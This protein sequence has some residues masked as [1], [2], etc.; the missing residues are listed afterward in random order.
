MK[1]DRIGHCLITYNYRVVSSVH[2]SLFF[3]FSFPS[4]LKDRVK[5]NKLIDSDNRMVVPERTGVGSGR[6]KQVEGVGYTVMEGDG[7]LDGDH[8]MRCTD[9]VLESCILE[10]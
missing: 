6:M 5:T 1:Q 9:D 7:S 2:M 4:S 8:T 3:F 10:T